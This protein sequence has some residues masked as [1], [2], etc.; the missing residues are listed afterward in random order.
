M[1]G[2]AVGIDY[3]LFILNRH[4]RQLKQGVEL[5]ESIGL[6]NG[7]SGTAVVFAGTTVIVALLAL[8]V[9][10]VPFLGLM[11]TVGAISVAVAILVA[12]TFT[13]AVLSVIG[14]RILRRKERARIGQRH[15]RPGAVP[16][17]ADLARDRSPSSAAS[18]CSPSI[19][20]P[21][22]DMRLGLPVGSSEAID[23]SQYKAYKVIEDKFGAGQNSPLVV[24]ADLPS[25][26]HRRRPAR[27]GGRDR[28]A[29]QRAGPR[30]GGRARSGPPTTAR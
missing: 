17:D 13:P 3:S 26:R 20:L 16:T 29:D 19:A 21:A 10:G 27:A 23:S 24:V 6:A 8:N 7:T 28:R 1:L 9:T 30:L 22:L 2:L 5:R 15:R 18:P 25:P 4:R 11:G 12:V 14:M